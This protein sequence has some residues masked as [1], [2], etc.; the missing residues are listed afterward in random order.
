MTMCLH[1]QGDKGEPMFLHNE[2]VIYHV[3]VWKRVGVQLIAL[4]IDFAHIK[5]DV[6]LRQLVHQNLSNEIW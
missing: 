5:S 3:R 2:V 1:T 6:S 4:Y